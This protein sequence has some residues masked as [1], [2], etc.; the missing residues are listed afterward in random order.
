MA[1]IKHRIGINGTAEQIYTL[2]TTNDGL[3]KWWTR[4]TR[5]AGEAGS[6]IHFYFA[7]T[8]VTFEINELVPDRFVRWH[9]VGNTPPDWMGSKVV[10][11]LEPQDHQTILL[12]KHYD[13]QKSSDFLA[14][15]S[16]KWGVFMMS[17]KACVETGEGNPY[18]D[19]IHIDFD[20]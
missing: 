6:T 3:A 2:L 8:L 11:E 18:P 20:E 16:T 4:D 7:Q 12:F 13:W 9:H 15:C 5:G 1:E 19:D 10:F 14:H 17:L